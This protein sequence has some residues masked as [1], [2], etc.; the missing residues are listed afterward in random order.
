MQLQ[1]NLFLFT[2]D[3]SSILVK[4]EVC[5]L[6][7]AMVHGRNH[8][9]TYGPWSCDSDNPYN[10]GKRDTATPKGLHS[11]CQSHFSFLHIFPTCDSDNPYNSRKRDTATPKGLH[12]VAQSHFSFL[13]IFPTRMQ[14]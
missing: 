3:N 2:L 14:I 7:D 6:F 9:G 8:Y 10:S 11:V 13:D 1:Y 5:T 12:L 4:F